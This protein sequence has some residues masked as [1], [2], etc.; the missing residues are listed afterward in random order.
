MDQMP[1]H[2]LIRELWPIG[3]DASPSARVA[4][5]FRAYTAM[6]GESQPTPVTDEFRRRV[7]EWI[8][9]QQSSMPVI[10]KHGHTVAL[11]HQRGGRLMPLI[12]G[13]TAEKVTWLQQAGCLSCLPDPGSRASA[14]YFGLRT[15]PFSAQSMTATDLKTLKERISLSMNGRLAFSGDWSEAAVCFN[16]VAVVGADARQKDVDN[17]AKGLLD[18][19]QGHLYLNDSQIAHLSVSRLRHAGDDGF[20]LMAARPVL[21][22]LADVIDRD[23][24]LG[25][26]G[27]PE[28]SLD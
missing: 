9:A 1:D 13:E 21:D 19:L 15:R 25:W 6:T 4:A 28:I 23:L 3:P 27:R 7:R 11:T 2:P 24:R 12:H 16:V 26:G 10:N 22:P 8:S 14:V 18:S 17:M 5:T 20:Y